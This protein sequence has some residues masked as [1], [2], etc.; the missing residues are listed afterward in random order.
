MANDDTEVKLSPD[1]RQKLIGLIITDFVGELMS[2]DDRE[3][4][5]M[6]RQ[7]LYKGIKGFRDFTDSELL[8]EATM[9]DLTLEKE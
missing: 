2:T 7:I 1:D 6:A 3:G 9:R 5:I 8:A 4:E